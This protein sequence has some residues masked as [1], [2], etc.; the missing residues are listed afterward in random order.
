MLHLSLL[1]IRP[2]CDAVS[3]S[4][5]RCLLCSLVVCIYA[6]VIMFS[7]DSWEVISYVVHAHLEDILGH[8]QSKLHAK[9]AVVFLVV[10]NVVSFEKT[11]VPVSLWDI[12][13][14][15]GAL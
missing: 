2:F 13:C 5:N 8:L 7:Y 10:L 12:S 3:I 4:C 1:E 14:R 6:D 15:V 11:V 9:E